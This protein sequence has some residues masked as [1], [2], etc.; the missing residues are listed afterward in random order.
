[1]CFGLFFAYNVPGATAKGRIVFEPM[2][3]LLGRF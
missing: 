3:R 2:A 1:L